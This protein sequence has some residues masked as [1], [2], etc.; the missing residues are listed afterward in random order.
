MTN[1]DR[2]KPEYLGRSVSYQSDHDRGWRKKNDRYYH[3]KDRKQLQESI[4][5]DIPVP[6]RNKKKHEYFCRKQNNTEIRYYKNF[7]NCPYKY[8]LEEKFISIPDTITSKE[9]YE[10][11][12]N[13]ILGVERKLEISLSKIPMK[14]VDEMEAIKEYWENMEIEEKLKLF[15]FD[16][17][18]SEPCIIYNEIKQKIDNEEDITNEEFIAFCWQYTFLTQINIFIQI[19]RLARRGNTKKFLK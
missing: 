5:H 8:N 6:V 12:L 18:P 16:N 3:H 9:N 10:Y 15:S 7:Y 2:K 19:K 13:F 14:F 1:S 4:T 17:S 11:L